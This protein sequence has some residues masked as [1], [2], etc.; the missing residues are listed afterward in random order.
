[1]DLRAEELYSYYKRELA[2]E[3]DLTEPQH[4]VLERRPEGIL[5]RKLK[6]QD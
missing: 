6:V 3:Y 4:V 5:I 1:M 2:A